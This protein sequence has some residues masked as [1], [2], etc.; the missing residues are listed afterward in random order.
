M[1]GLQ[2]KNQVTKPNQTTQT[3]PGGSNFTPNLLN[4]FSKEVAP[5]MTYI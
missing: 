5:E 2:T 1:E 3:Q 4:I